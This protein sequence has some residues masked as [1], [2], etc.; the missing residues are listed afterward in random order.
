MVHHVKQSGDRQETEM[1]SEEGKQNSQQEISTTNSEL[2]NAGNENSPFSISSPG[3]GRDDDDPL[4]QESQEGDEPYTASVN[5]SPDEESTPKAP[6]DAEIDLN[7]QQMIMLSV[8]MEERTNQLIRLQADF[9]NFRKRT[10][11][12]REDSEEQVKGSTINELLPVVDT[13]E[14]A[15]SHIKPQTEGEMIIHRSYQS[16]Y[17]QLVDCLKRLGV[18]PMRSEGKPFDP[19]L[20]EAVMREPT[21]QY[22][23]DTVMEELV[24]GYMLGEK[25]LR[26]AMV[27]VAS[28]PEPV[29]PSDEGDTQKDDGAEVG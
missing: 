18:S 12:E 6:V 20:H 17:K 22:P 28:A 24:R 23:E 1:H 4:Q 7:Q 8:Q 3:S 11:K 13:F 14:R 2:E 15:R 25:V 19:L 26:H 29:I 5:I 27:K 9:D 10:Y 21:D 16:V